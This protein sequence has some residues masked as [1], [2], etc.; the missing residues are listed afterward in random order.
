MRSAT[1]RCALV[2]LA[3]LSS[4]A[5]ASPSALDKPAFTATP[6]ELLSVAKAAP[7]RAADVVLLRIDDDVSYDDR[8]RVTS[9]WR[10]VFAVTTKAGVD[11]WDTLSSTWLPAYQDKPTVRARVIDPNGRAVELD[12]T[13]VTDA[14]DQDASQ[15]APTDR[16]RLHAPLPR[17]S[18]G[19]VVEEQ[20]T[21]VDREPLPGGGHA[22]SFDIAGTYAVESE[23]IRLSSPAAK[24]LRT[25]V[26]GMAAKPKTETV[27]GRQVISYAF[28]RIPAQAEYEGYAPSDARPFAYVIAT[29]VASWSA[30]AR[31]Y[32]ALVDKRI[33]QGPY[34]LPA[35]LPKTATLD[36]VRA[37]T[38]WVHAHVQ[39]TGIELSDTSLTPA[40]PADIVKR[41]AAD[42]KDMAT[43]LVAL[44]RQAGVRAELALIDVGPGPGIDRDLPGANL[45][46]HVIVRARI[47]KT[48]VWIDPGER[49][50]A[51]GRL[52]WQDQ[53]R[54]ALVISDDTSALVTTPAAVATDNLIREQRTFELAEAG[55]AKVT[56]VS[57]ELGVFESGQRAWI[58]DSPPDTVR[59][60]LGDYVKNEYKA[61]LDSYKAT[62]ADDLTKP[63][64]VT[65]V[66]TDSSRAYSDRDAI[67]AYLFS[68]DALKKLPDVL[69]NPKADAPPRKLDVSLSTPHIYE[70]ENRL[71]LPPG[72]TMPSPAPD[73]TRELGVF[74]LIEK[75]R[76]DGQAFVVTFRFEATKPRL[77]PAEVTK[78]QQAIRELHDEQ[79]THIVIPHTGIALA[80]SGKYRD[81]IVEVNKLIKLHPK[82]ALHHQQLAEVL[83]KAGAGE[84]ARR[85]A[86][87]ATELEPNNADAHV[88][89]GWVLQHD[90]FGHWLG[91]DHDRAAARAA[92]EKA[93]KLD[94]KHVGAAQDLAELLERNPRGRRFET[95]SDF[96]GAIEAWRAAIA[97]E[98]S[99]DRS[100][101]LATVL[102]WSGDGAAA[103]KVLRA[104]PQAER[105]DQLLITAVAL[106]SGTEAAL[107]V[108]TSLATGSTKTKHISVA[109]S[110]LF[111]TRHY[112]LMRP[113]FA[114][115]NVKPGSQQ[116][117]MLQKVARSDKPF[118]AGKNPQDVMIEMGLLVLDPS[119]K[120]NPFWD[121]AV[122]DE[123]SNGA[124]TELQPILAKNGLMTNGL[125][126]DIMR[127]AMPSTV[128]G[129][130]A[131]WRIELDQ[132]RAGVYVASDRGTP[133]VIG[134][135][136]V[137]QGVGRHI[138]R[139]LAKNDEKTALRL[140]DWL[141]KDLANRKE[142][143]AHRFKEVWGT[144]LPRTRKDIELAAA[145]L[146]AKTDA[147]H[148]IPVLTQ[149]KPSSKSGQFV[150][151]WVLSDLYMHTARW[152]ELLDHAR[153]WAGRAPS[154]TSFPA[155]AEAYALAH[156]GKF[157]DADRVL[158]DALAKDP[159][160][161]EL[162]FTNADLAAGRGQLAEAVHR[163]EPLTKVS[164]PQSPELNNTAWLKVVEGTDVQGAVV[165]AR[166][167]VQLTPNQRNVTN[168]AAA[169][170]AEVGELRE[171]LE[172]L[173]AS[174]R[175]IDTRPVDA[176]LYVHARI[177]E[178]LGYV[179]DAVAIY[180]Q[181]KPDVHERTFIPGAWSLAQRRLKA[182]GVKN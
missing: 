32:R 157:D 87:K 138:F 26:F 54:F 58:H 172:H 107:R 180:R 57:R 126:E 19:A 148:A 63:F 137:P 141:A 29:P 104:M 121:K 52:P 31:E 156:L 100:Y 149:C 45:F 44:L 163:M 79:A 43:L 2:A 166:R 152:S 178:Q 17:L 12:P 48:D 9:S 20:I 83:I 75:Q 59:K 53:G 112:D 27:G 154:G 97:L 36:T 13:L 103:E 6:A 30:I 90:T 7:T 10:M 162:V 144:N 50:A 113:L 131:A 22:H 143:V 78:T 124:A 174:V 125:L 159:D 176:D 118:K 51:P 34:T 18:I 37:V 14:P 170:E 89:L 67:N 65:V 84:A 169:A 101:S 155:V 8:G 47:G 182:L 40:T 25:A 98:G 135:P 93:R 165:M 69:G 64:E 33:G 3:L 71:V 151:D 123:L 158:A 15:A 177:V 164:S 5:H 128:E 81:A 132:T 111:M 56:E 130:A 60:N 161:R 88:V 41:G 72:Y 114:E 136:E 62:S 82:H 85:S 39:D 106:S 122:R 108:A 160:A 142:L 92:L 46:D 173:E 24:K 74:K 120:T 42:A 105:R 119:R 86:R 91:F 4:L 70:I 117:I 109:A 28:D 96:R 61:T 49:L 150:C 147:A 66:V 77:T 140:L 139:L 55:G 179:D 1:F 134:A 171:A 127:S 21:T 73:K 145:V 116:E 68:S 168:T 110:L 76:V 167:A 16:R 181:I 175:A 11:G 99:E 102:L 129:D 38:A 94:P 133:K 115:A 95:G 80:E 35:E 146:T 153:A 23:R